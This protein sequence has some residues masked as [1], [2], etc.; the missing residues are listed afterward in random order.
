MTSV[1]SVV[2]NSFLVSLRLEAATA[3]GRAPPH[4]SL[5]CFPYKRQPP[6]SRRSR[7]SAQGMVSPANPRKLRHENWQCRCKISCLKESLFAW[8]IDRI[9]LR[10]A[11]RLG[12]G[13]ADGN[14]RPADRRGI[15]AGRR[16]ARHPFYAP[17]DGRYGRGRTLGVLPAFQHSSSNHP[18]T[19]FR[20]TGW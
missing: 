2:K 3:A 1:F 9:L 18:S 8:C 6:G 19:L 13:L 12:I 10:G 7:W 5:P 15:Q 11:Q 14:P 4:S 17:G 16:P 20:M